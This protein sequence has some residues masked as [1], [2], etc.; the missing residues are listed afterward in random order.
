MSITLGNIE[1]LFLIYVNCYACFGAGTK[2]LGEFVFVM[3]GV[4]TDVSFLIQSNYFSHPLG[5]GKGNASSQ[6]GQGTFVQNVCR[7]FCGSDSKCIQ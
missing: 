3:L 6:R 1:Q 4:V 5:G 2:Y 7:K